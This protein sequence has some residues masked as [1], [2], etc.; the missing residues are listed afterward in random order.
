MI[1]LCDGAPS[2]YNGTYGGLLDKKLIEAVKKV[3]KTGIKLFCYGINSPR[4]EQY[5]APDFHLIN[6][7]KDLDIKALKKLGNYLLNKR[8]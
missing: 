4:V 7:L 5:Y 8:R 1:V 6:D 3:R 2:G